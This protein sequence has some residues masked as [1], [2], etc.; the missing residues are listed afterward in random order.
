MRLPRRLSMTRH[1]EFAAVR[2]RGK[3]QAT[4]NFVMASL[5]DPSLADVKIGLITSRRAARRAV[6]RNRIRRRLRAI[7]VAHGEKLIPGRYL[8]L[9]ARRRASEA[10]FPEL[11]ADWLHLA[12]RLGILSEDQP[13][14]S[15]PG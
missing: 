4:R 6:V 3:S 5:Q 2:T 15:R 14:T 9:I 8:V 11:E 13:E 12:G 1:E 10:S 7:M